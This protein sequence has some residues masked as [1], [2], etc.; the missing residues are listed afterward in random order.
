[1]KIKKREKLKKPDYLLGVYK[2]G[3]FTAYGS[4]KSVKTKL[5][6]RGKELIKQGKTIIHGNFKKRKFK[7]FE[8]K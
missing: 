1:M 3:K 2:N 7:P 4:K 5:N 8:D 6:K